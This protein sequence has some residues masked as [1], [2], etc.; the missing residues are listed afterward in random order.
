MESGRN[1]LEIG[2]SPAVME[3]V[4]RDETKVFAGMVKEAEGA[5]LGTGQE[6][7]ERRLR[8][9]GLW[10]GSWAYRAGESDR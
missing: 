7:L 4:G 2:E 10:G 3:V 6:G 1:G 5:D 8:H 9:R